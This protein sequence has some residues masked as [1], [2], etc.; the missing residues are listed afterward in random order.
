VKHTI[1][2]DDEL[3]G[4]QLNVTLLH[5]IFHAINNEL[6]HTILDSL[7]EQ[8]YQVLSDNHLLRP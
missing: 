2:L 8:L 1:T 5:E 4:S 6:D 3:T 7:G